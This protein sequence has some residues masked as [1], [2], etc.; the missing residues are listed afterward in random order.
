VR[1]VSE[2]RTVDPA[3]IAAKKARM[4][5]KRLAALDERLMGSARR[6]LQGL[7]LR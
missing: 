7:Q 6:G 5:D 1:L 4:R 3:T 2:L